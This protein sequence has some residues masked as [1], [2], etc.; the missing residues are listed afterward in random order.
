MST[1]AERLNAVLSHISPTL[2]AAVEQGW[3]PAGSPY[4][5]DEFNGKRRIRVTDP[6][7]GETYSGVGETIEAALAKLEA[8][9]GLTQEPPSAPST[10]AGGA[11]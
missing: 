5:I 7:S 11:A 6:E 10:P 9:V 1:R 2:K 3:G 4:Q 8:R